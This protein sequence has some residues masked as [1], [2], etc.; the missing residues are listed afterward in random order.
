MIQLPLGTYIPYIAKTYFGL[1]N[2]PVHL[3]KIA[4]GDGTIAAFEVYRLTSVVRLVLHVNCGNSSLRFV[5]TTVLETY[6]QI[7]NFDPEVFN[8]FREQCVPPSL[9]CILNLKLR[10]GTSLWT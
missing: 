9:P 10:Q 7:I 8:Y 6:P 5:Q 1:A 4:I 3:R 2:P